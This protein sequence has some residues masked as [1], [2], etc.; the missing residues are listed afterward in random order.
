M[1][2]CGRRGTRPSCCSGRFRTALSGSWRLAKRKIRHQP[3]SD[4]VNLAGGTSGKPPAPTIAYPCP[5]LAA[6]TADGAQGFVSRAARSSLMLMTKD[7]RPAFRTIDGWA[8]SVLLEAGAIRECEEHG[9]MKDRADPHARQRAVHIAR[10][11]PPFGVSPDEADR[12][13]V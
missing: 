7:R 3:P 11:N 1:S 4:A 8:R 5:V 12:K 10:G 9:W 13:S 2:G 6:G